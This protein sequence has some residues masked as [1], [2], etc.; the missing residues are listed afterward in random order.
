MTSLCLNP[1]LE[2]LKKSLLF[3]FYF[4][5]DFCIQYSFTHKGPCLNDGV[6]V[7][8]SKTFAMDAKCRCK[9]GFS[10][11]FCDTVS[12]VCIVKQF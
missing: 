2:Y 3:V 8:S 1:R 10:G 11:D 12:R 7:S 6:L 5:V 9:E 4:P